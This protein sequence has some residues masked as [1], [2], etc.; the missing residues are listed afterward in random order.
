MSP[1]SQP[2][3]HPA[4]AAQGSAGTEGARQ[5]RPAE[6]VRLGAGRGD[7]WGPHPSFRFEPHRRAGRGTGAGSARELARAGSDGSGT[8]LG[9]VRASGGLLRASGWKHRM[10]VFPRGRPCARRGAA[11]EGRGAGGAEE[12]RGSGAVP[13]PSAAAQGGGE[14]RRSA[15]R[16]RAQCARGA[17]AAREAKQRGAAR[18]GA[19]RRGGG[20]AGAVVPGAAP[21]EAVCGPG[22]AA[23]S[24]HRRG[25][26][27]AHAVA[28]DGRRAG[29]VR[30]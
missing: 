28:K 23:A 18:C 17:P 22:D 4:S 30:R 5:G 9:S 14:G 1:T 6:R 27:A 13:R 7:C 29:S 15:W 3:S 11:R 26:A 21:A 24:A 8:C 12:R 20:G 16:G 10:T 19:A 2:A 25:L